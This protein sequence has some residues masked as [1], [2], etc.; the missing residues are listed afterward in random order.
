M[1]ILSSS[2]L[3]VKASEREDARAAAKLAVGNVSNIYTI[4]DT[5][6]KAGRI[7]RP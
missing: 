2:V 4:I 7:I 5:L 3:L 6:S 1:R